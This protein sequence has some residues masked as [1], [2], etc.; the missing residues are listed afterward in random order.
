M[1]VIGCDFVEVVL[2]YEGSMVIGYVC[3]Y[4]G[5]WDID[6]VRGKY[7]YVLFD[8]IFIFFLFGNISLYKNMSFF[9]K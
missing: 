6:L 7:C 3:G 4:Y 5:F 2:V 9:R 8:F 1:R